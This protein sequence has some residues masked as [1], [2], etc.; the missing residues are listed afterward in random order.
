M[1]KLLVLLL[2]L[3]FGKA[4]GQN[5]VLY[6][7]DVASEGEVPASGF[8]LLQQHFHKYVDDRVLS[9]TS[10]LVSKGEQVRW[11]F[12]GMQNMETGTPMAKN[13][14]F[15]LAS[16]TKPIVS[17]AVMILVEE[18]KLSLDD[19]VP[20]FIPAFKKLR[21]YQSENKRV[22]PKSPITIRHLLSHTGGISSGF[23]PSPAGQI[24]SATMREQ[25]PE[26]LEAI[27]EA[28]AETPLAFHPGEG[29]TYSYST[30]VLAYIV[31]QVSGQPIDQFLNKRIFEPLKMKDTGFQ[32]PAEKRHR[33]AS[34][35]AKGDEG[36]LKAIDTP[37]DSPYTNGTYFPRGNGGLT[38]TITDYYRFAK[39]LLNGGTFGDVRI[40]KKETVDLMTANQLP[41]SLLPISIA[42]NDLPGQG[43]GLGVGVLT[44]DPP[45]GS[46]GD[47]YWPG[48]AFTY[49]FVNPKEDLVGI[50]MTQ[51][52]DMS[53][54][55]LIWEFHELAGKVFVRE[56]LEED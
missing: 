32:V 3:C 35:Y 6:V 47:Y 38:S 10:M 22:K 4:W 26:S 41:K 44:E 14:I 1:K 8:V 19:E 43:F 33:F 7:D 31:E 27:I 48:A 2:L 30:D 17:V 15:R 12:Y 54:M 53:K 34:L 50:F 40:L 16:M 42:G 37:A 46:K 23:D 56:V 25:K 39:M 29:W 51:L 45:F 18:G 52:S 21:V 55:H 36:Q 49:F 28:L 13:T 24:C 5:G 20:R 11:D 9:G